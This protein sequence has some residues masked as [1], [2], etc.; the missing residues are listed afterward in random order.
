MSGM[1]P[2]QLKEYGWPCL[3]KAGDG[4]GEHCKYDAY[5][6]PEAVSIFNRVEQLLKADDKDALVVFVDEA[7]ARVKKITDVCS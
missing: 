1:T 5:F 2:D 6:I 4:L 7:K 3:P